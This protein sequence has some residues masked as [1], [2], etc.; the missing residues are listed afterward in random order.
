[1]NV[2]RSRSRH[3]RAGRRRKARRAPRR[4]ERGRRR[5]DRAPSSEGPSARAGEPSEIQG[6]Q[7]GLEPS[8]RHRCRHEKTS[9]RELF[10]HRGERGQKTMDPLVDQVLPRKKTTGSLS[11]SMWRGAAGAP[12]PAGRGVARSD[13]CQQLQQLPGDHSCGRPRGC[14]PEHPGHPAVALEPCQSRRLRKWSRRSAWQRDASDRAEC[15]WECADA[16]PHLG[17]DGTDAALAVGVEG[18]DGIGPGTAPR[19]LALGSAPAR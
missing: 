9:P 10:E 1:V 14:G 5:L 6:G 17:S 7:K 13:A 16:V 11:Q 4:P 15:R 2:T 8:R 19:R 18:H 3:R 12:R